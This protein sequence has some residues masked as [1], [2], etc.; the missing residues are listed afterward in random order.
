MHLISK[1]LSCLLCASL[2]AGS[3]LPVL[4]ENSAPAIIID[5]E[6][7][8]SVDELLSE[9]VPAWAAEEEAVPTEGEALE[10]SCK[11]AVLLEMNSG[12]VLYEQNAHEKLPIASVT[13]IMT[14]LLIMEAID[15]GTITYQDMVTCSAYAASMGGSQIWLE[16]GETMSVD[17]MLKA[18][19]VVSANDCCAAMA[20]YLAGSVESFVARMNEKASALGMDDTQF[21]DCSGMSDD[22]YSSAYDVALMSQALMQYSD[23]TRYTTIWMDSLRDGKSQLVNTNKLVRYYDGIT[24]LKTGTTS[25]AGHNLSATA[26]RDGLKLAR[27]MLD[28]G[29]ANYGVYTPTVEES[30]LTPVKVLRGTASCVE[31]T[32]DPPQPLLVKKG[33]EKNIEKTVSL[34]ADVEAPVYADQVVGT[35]TLSLDGQEL[36]SY[37]IRAKEEVPR[38]TVGAAYCRLLSAL[39][40]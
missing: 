10:L 32:A 8:E 16:E 37:N 33:Q 1:G 6:S 12:T 24:G 11:S 20:E 30:E 22:G 9:T 4:A 17:D 38:M 36:A 34:S 26:E 29:F 7:G 28:Y 14:L 27:K 39:I 23:I 18:I 35:V 15:A 19:C 2:L 13:K 21:V 3:A 31:V 5:T 25:T 40:A